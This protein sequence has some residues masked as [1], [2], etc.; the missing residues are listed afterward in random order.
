[1]DSRVVD[2]DIVGLRSRRAA[3]K[4][5]HEGSLIRSNKNRLEMVGEMISS[6]MSGVLS[7]YPPAS[8]DLD[9]GTWCAAVG[10][11]LYS[12]LMEVVF[13]VVITVNLV[14]IIIETDT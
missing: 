14:V 4:M 11:A 10:K 12:V 8:V 13:A 5:A 9:D 1:M 6:V 3:R 7:S 2:D